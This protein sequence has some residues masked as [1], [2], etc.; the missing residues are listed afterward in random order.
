[1]VNALKQE[2]LLQKDFFKNSSVS[3]IYF[4]GGTP[5][6]LNG[7]DIDLLLSSIYKNF[8]LEQDPEITLEAN[9]DDLN[10]HKLEE[11]KKLGIN[12][13]SIGIQSFNDNH[14]KYLNRAHSSN[15]AYNCLENA[16]LLGFHNISL[17][18]IYGIPFQDHS[19]WEMDLKTAIGFK[20]EH[21]S[22]YCL[23]IEE[24]TTFGNWLKKGKLLEAEEEYAAEQFEL[25][26]KSLSANDYKQYEISNFS[27]DGYE[28]RHNSN[29]WNYLPYLGIGPGAHSFNGKFRQSNISN[30]SK[31][32]KSIYQHIL[33]ATLE[34]LSLRDQINEYILT[35]LRT[36]K[37]CDLEKLKKLF[38]IDLLKNSEKYISY[39][40]KEDLARITNNY[41]I[42]NNKGKLLADK[43]AT[44]LFL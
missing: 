21:I 16:R 15:E 22:S 35:S 26:L 37:G 42:L 44:D 12:R 20:P 5:S 8:K 23:T 28:S 39:L 43:I 19:I 24:K 2:I 30:N 13:L 18:L 9:P 36:S 40:V 38:D 6:I 29:Y 1:M 11:I 14:L 34:E 27:L 4:G 31:Y 41:L 17:D 33:P 32:I 3:T 10:L 7:S 25:L